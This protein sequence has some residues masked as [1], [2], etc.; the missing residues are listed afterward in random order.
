VEPFIDA[1]DVGNP[2]QRV[3]RNRRDLAAFPALERR[4]AIE[5]EK[6]HV[7]HFAKP[8]LVCNVKECAQRRTGEVLACTS[9]IR[10]ES[11]KVR[12]PIANAYIILKISSMRRI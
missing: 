5:P 6:A 8:P 4:A 2:F 11:G 9:F 3:F 7:L 1:K 10:C 12:L